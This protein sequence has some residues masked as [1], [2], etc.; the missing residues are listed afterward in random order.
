MRGAQNA[1]VTTRGFPLPLYWTLALKDHLL[2][3][4]M[5]FEHL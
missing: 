3:L 5:I 1:M 4:G 2:S